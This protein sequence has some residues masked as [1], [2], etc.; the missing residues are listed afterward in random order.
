[1]DLE[2]KKRMASAH[3]N[4]AIIFYDELNELKKKILSEEASIGGNSLSNLQ[5][6]EELLIKVGSI[7]EMQKVL[8]ESALV[9]LEFMSTL[10]DIE[11]EDINRK[12]K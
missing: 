2:S 7:N 9:T 12:T 4:K 1:M 3:F 5:R 6:K 10:V 11:L 8:N